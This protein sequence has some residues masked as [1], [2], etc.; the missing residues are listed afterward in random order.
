ML[1]LH[2]TRR[3]VIDRSWY[4][5][6]ETSLDISDYRELSIALVDACGVVKLNLWTV[7]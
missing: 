4:L 1:V 3:A 7:G 5:E 2:F 6:G